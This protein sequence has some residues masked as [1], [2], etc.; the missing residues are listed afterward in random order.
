MK[1]YEAWSASAMYGL[2]IPGHV[3]AEMVE[4]CKRSD[5]IETGGIIV[6]YYNRQHDCAIVTTCSGPPKDSVRK[7]SHFRRGVRGLRKWV[8]ELWALRAKRYYLGEW[9]FHPLRAP[10]ASDRDKWQMKET[11]G[12]EACE[13]PEPVMVILGGDPEGE[14]TCKSFIY[15]QKEGLIELVRGYRSRHTVG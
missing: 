6:G 13:C 12:K 4:L 11:A 10:I 9:H 5:G 7:R 2:R 15:L 14:W 1:N 3:L 8:L